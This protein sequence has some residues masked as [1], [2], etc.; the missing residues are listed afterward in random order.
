MAGGTTLL[1]LFSGEDT[2]AK[3]ENFAKV[4][5]SCTVTLDLPER[6]GAKLAAL[7]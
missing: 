4:Y 1:H 3:S 6:I 5:T 2:I 7:R